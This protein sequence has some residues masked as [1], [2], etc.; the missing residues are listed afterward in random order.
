MSVSRHDKL[1]KFFGRRSEIIQRLAVFVPVT[2][3]AFICDC[4]NTL[5]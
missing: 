1:I 4:A 5:R 2:G 3:W